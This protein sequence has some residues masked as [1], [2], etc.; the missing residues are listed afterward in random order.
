MS[1]HPTIPAA[2]VFSNSLRGQ[3]ILSVFGF[4]LAVTL[5]AFSPSAEAQIYSVVYTFPTAQDG[6]RPQGVIEDQAGNLYGATY[7]G[8]ANGVGAIFKLDAAGNETVLHSFKGPDGNAPLGVVRDAAGNIYGATAFGGVGC[9]GDFGCGTVFKLDT[10][11]K[12]TVLHRFG[13]HGDGRFPGS[14]LVRDAAGNLYG[15]TYNGGIL[16]C[17]S[18]GRGCGTIFKIDASGNETVLHRFTGKSDGSG[19]NGLT[20]DEAGDLYGTTPAGTVFKVDASGRFSVLYR[21]T[22]GA[23]GESPYAGVIRTQ[24]ATF[25]APHFLGRFRIRNGL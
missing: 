8:G 2:K 17:D 10:N 1:T 15:T 14:G 4:A 3:R 18:S 7:Y 11:G 24:R 6:N 5:A 12:E 16:T 22:G 19:P 20:L 13:R 23:D 25:M 21:F 9:S